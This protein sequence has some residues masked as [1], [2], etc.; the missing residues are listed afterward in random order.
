[1][2]INP[3]IPIWL[4]GIICVLFLVLK[5]KGKINYIRQIVI[6]V[7]LFVVNLRI[8]VGGND[9]PNVSPNVDIVFVVDNTISMLAEDYNGT[10]RRMDAVREDCEYIMQQF[11]G[12]SYSVISFAATVDKM[13]PYT[14]DTNMIRESLSLL[15]GQKEYYATGTSLNKVMENIGGLLENERDTYKIMFFIS[16]GEITSEEE[17]KRFSQLD[18]YVDNG[19]VLGY[20][21]SEG[22]KMKVQSSYYD[23]DE[24]QYL[25]YY[26][27]DY[28]RRKAISVID[29]DNLK[30]IADDFGVDYIH[31][32]KQSEIDD[33]IDELRAE[34]P[35]YVDEDEEYKKGYV[36]IYYIFIIPLLA[37]MIVD[38]IYYRKKL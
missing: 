9:V 12:A 26:D 13:T 7:L 16:D 18:K 17:L 8:M 28:N 20:G 31:M 21:T 22:G 36:D 3:I 30:S 25:T 32:T 29:E 4:M 35:E 23:E 37:L 38:Y 27:E 6:V 19:A 1:M 24:P 5:R 34:L 33:K 10:E 11:P 15:N 2:I 14:V